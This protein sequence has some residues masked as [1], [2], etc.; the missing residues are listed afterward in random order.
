MPRLKSETAVLVADITARL[1]RIVEIAK[2]EGHDQAL[3]DIRALVG[4]GSIPVKRGPGRPRKVVPAD[5]GL[6]AAPARKKRR[7][8][9]WTSMTPEQ[10]AE[11]VRRMLAGRGLKPKSDR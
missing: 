9:P 8:N 5:A 11:R 1:Q 7:K 10:K 6:G 3:T 2:K 4:G